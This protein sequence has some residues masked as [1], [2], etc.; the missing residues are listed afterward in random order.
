MVSVVVPLVSVRFS[1]EMTPVFFAPD[2]V[3]ASEPVPAIVSVPEQDIAV[4]SS[5]VTEFAPTSISSASPFIVSTPD[6]VMPDSET[7]QFAGSFTSTFPLIGPD[8][9]TSVPDSVIS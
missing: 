1:A 5:V 3:A 4:A 7:R 8:S 6:I 2:E 9:V